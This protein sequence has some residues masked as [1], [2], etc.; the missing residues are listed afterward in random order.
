M[1]V[2]HSSRQ[3]VVVAEPGIHISVLA[4]YECFPLW[5]HDADGMAN[6]SPAELGLPHKLANDLLVW[7]E[8]YE[9]TLNTSDPGASGFA[10]AQAE[11]GFI[12]RGRALTAR[13]AAALGPA[14][15]VEFDPGV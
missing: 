1:G 15:T 4:E 9:R 14:V 11:A 12:A 6:L 10:D 8:D 3:N 5:R 13:V 2:T 7:S